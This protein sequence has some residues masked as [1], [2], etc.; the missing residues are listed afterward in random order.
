M[1]ERVKKKKHIVVVVDVTEKS[2]PFSPRFLDR[3][4]S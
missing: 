2:N 1:S 4:S 3:L